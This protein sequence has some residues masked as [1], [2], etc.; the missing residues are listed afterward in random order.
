MERLLKASFS[1]HKSGKQPFFRPLAVPLYSFGSEKTASADP[2]RQSPQ[3]AERFFDKL[4]H[5]HITANGFFLSGGFGKR[6]HRRGV[7]LD[8]TF[9][10]RY[11]GGGEKRPRRLGTSVYLVLALNRLTGPYFSCKLP[12]KY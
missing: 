12:T 11:F 3:L 7:L 10:P 5:W 2:S 4:C 9:E 1:D 6:E 8:S